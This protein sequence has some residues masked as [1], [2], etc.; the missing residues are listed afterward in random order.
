MDKKCRDKRERQFS[1][2][3]KAGDGDR[4]LLQEQ[5]EQRADKSEHDSDAQL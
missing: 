2:G 4:N 5:S 3:E 1:A